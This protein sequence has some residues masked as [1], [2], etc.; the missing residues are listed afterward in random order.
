MAKRRNRGPRRKAGGTSG[1]GGGYSKAQKMAKRRIAAGK[2]ISSVKAANRASMRKKAAERNAKFKQTRVQT[3]GGRKTSFTK[4]EQARIRAAGYTVE[5]YSKAAYSEDGG[6][7]ARE[8]AAQ[9]QKNLNKKLANFDAKSY[10]ARYKDLRDAFGTDEAAARKHYMTHGFDENRDISKFKAPQQKFAEGRAQ[11]Q[12][13]NIG[14]VLQ[15]VQNVGKFIGN[16][17]G[18]SLSI[19]NAA[20]KDMQQLNQR[21]NQDIRGRQYSERDKTALYKAPQEST[22]KADVRDTI[23]AVN[24]V[25]GIVRADDKRQ[26]FADANTN[27]LKNILTKGYPAFQ[28]SNLAQVAGEMAGLPS[29]FKMQ[30]QQPVD[31]LKNELSKVTIG[32]RD[33]TYKM[34]SDFARDVGT[35]PSYGLIARGIHQFRPVAENK[36]GSIDA[37]SGGNPNATFMDKLRM[38]FDIS[39][40]TV[41]GLNKAVSYTHL[42]LPTTR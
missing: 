5:G 12:L 17:P 27:D 33:S 20:R 40:P 31:K 11:S 37:A 21:Y 19:A 32:D 13:G 14:K 7:A 26:A 22:L 15:G 2:T 42:T 39:Q 24:T 4:A 35:D 29:N 10:L 28:A 1:R 23:G 6:R 3:D 41:P 38:S 9:R 34:I 25:R 8:K 16:N 36:D 18:D 30:I